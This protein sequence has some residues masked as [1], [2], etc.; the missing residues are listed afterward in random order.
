MT[1]MRWGVARW[2]GDSR[3]EW[4]DAAVAVLPM[5]TTRLPTLV[6]FMAATIR[7]TADEHLPRSVRL[8]TSPVKCRRLGGGNVSRKKPSRNAHCPCGS[9]K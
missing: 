4:V 1:T 9:G 6:R 2:G 3:W 7:A 8:A 5:M